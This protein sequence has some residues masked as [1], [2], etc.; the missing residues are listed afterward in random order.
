MSTIKTNA[1]Q[2]TAGKPILN[3][4][5]SILQVVQGILTS[6]VSS[7]VGQN[8]MVSIGLSASITP[9]NSANKILIMVTLGGVSGNVDT[10]HG[11]K[12]MRNT[13]TDTLIGDSAGNRTRVFAQNGHPYS[14]NNWRGSEVSMAYVDSPATT[15][16]TTYTVFGG[17]NQ[18]ATWYVNRTGRDN[19]GANED[20]RAASSI[21][22]MEVSG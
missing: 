16:S 10:T 6:T 3:S 20:S 7:S 13:S 5:G 11:W 2:T 4:T 22:L 12:I 9:S 8:A 14:G 21:I 15:S 18:S 19:D 1:I 17:G